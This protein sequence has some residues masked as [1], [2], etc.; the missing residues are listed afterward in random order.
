MAS[1]TQFQSR[2]FPSGNVWPPD[3][4]EES[5]LG[6]D[7]HQTTI[8]NL[9]LGINGI[10]DLQ[11]A[12]DLAVPWRA[13]S[14]MAILGCMRADGTY[15]RTYP[16]IFVYPR[17]I[18]P[19]RGS[20]T[21]EVDGPPVLVVEVLSAS[22]YEV[23]LDLVRGKGYT[24]ARAGVREYVTIDPTR[25]LLEPGIRAWRLVE[26][27]YHPWEPDAAGHWRSVEIG[28]SIGLEGAQVSVYTHDGTRTL[29]EGEVERERARLQAELERLRR[30]LAERQGPEPPRDT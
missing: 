25:A 4:T 30:L 13:L 8:T 6:T 14:Q 10:A 24:Y 23:D 27:A 16:D 3:D 2:P 18:D 15:Y 19:E 29:R 11:R 7:L 5:I 20:V 17:A 22:T 12:P 21:L 26:G 1:E 9:R 28:V